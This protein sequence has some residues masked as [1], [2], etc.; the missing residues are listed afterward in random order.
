MKNNFLDQLDSGWGDTISNVYEKA[1]DYV[2]TIIF[3]DEEKP[4]IVQPKKINDR[5]FNL[6]T[7]NSSKIEVNFLSFIKSENIYKINQHIVDSRQ[8]R[9]ARSDE[10]RWVNHSMN[11]ITTYSNIIINGTELYSDIFKRLINNSYPYNI[12][13][14]DMKILN[15][16]EDVDNLELV[17]SIGKNASATNNCFGQIFMMHD[18]FTDPFYF[19]IENENIDEIFRTLE[20][21]DNKDI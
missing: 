13:S 5:H 12:H 18:I 6:L 14:S 1:N 20:E 2:F 8:T 3:K 16:D 15:S 17:V 10:E 7:K 9:N 19:N 4:E 21:I 11:S